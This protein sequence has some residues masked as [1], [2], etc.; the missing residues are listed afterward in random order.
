MSQ[1]NYHININ[2]TLIPVTKEQYLCY[3]RFKRRMRYFEHDIKTETPVR[4]KDGNIIGYA[5]SKEDS[6]ERIYD[7][8]TDFAAE[9]ESV[10]DTAIRNCMSDKLH[11]VL[12][13]LPTGEQALIFALYFEGQTEREYAKVLGVKQ[14]SINERKLRI[15]SKLN[16]LLQN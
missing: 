2:G 6:F 5:P 3:Y 1:E 12:K 7:A 15:L 4:D 9:Q 11:E 16:K 8:G 10:E 14:Q 13:K